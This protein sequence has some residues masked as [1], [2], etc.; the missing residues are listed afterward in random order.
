MPRAAADWSRTLLLKNWSRLKL[1]YIEEAVQRLKQLVKD[2]H[3]G[4]RNNFDYLAWSQNCVSFKNGH[5]C[6]FASRVVVDGTAVYY[7][8][9]VTIIGWAIGADSVNLISD[10]KNLLCHSTPPW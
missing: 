5:H 10:I 3:L 2:W 6:H 1:V 8:N 7:N 4:E 9:G